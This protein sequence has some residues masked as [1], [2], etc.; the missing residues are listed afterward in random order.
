MTHPN[1]QSIVK[2]WLDGDTPTAHQ[3]DTVAETYPWFTLGPVMMLRKNQ[4]LTAT[5]R[6]SLALQVLK[7]SPLPEQAALA[8]DTNLQAALACFYPINVANTPGT[9]QTIQKF[10]NTYGSAD[11]AEEQLL[12]KLIFNPTP[13]YAQVLAREEEQSVPND[14]EAPEGSADDLINRFIIAQ[15]QNQAPASPPPPPQPSPASQPPAADD[16]LLSQSLAK[17]YIKR[18]NYSKALEIITDLN[19]HFPEKSRYFADQI[20]FLNK[21]I[22]V[23]DAASP[24]SGTANRNA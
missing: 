5:D 17:I 8:S 7:N 2:A 10:L 14:G 9:D 4:Q 21:L 24:A 15:K 6:A 12:E 16:G 23:R 3:I 13:D 18:G 11:P 19:L 20:R 1:I 22:A